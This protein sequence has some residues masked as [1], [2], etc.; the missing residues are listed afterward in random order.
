MKMKNSTF[1]KNFVVNTSLLLRVRILWWMHSRTGQWS[2]PD[3]PDGLALMGALP[4]QH[5]LWQ[6]PGVLHRRESVQTG[7]I[8]SSV[9]LSYPVLLRWQICWSLGD[10]GMWGTTLSSSTIAGLI[11]RGRHE[12]CPSRPTRRNIC[13][14]H[15]Q[16][17][18]I[19]QIS[20]GQTSTRPQKVSEWNPRSSRLYSQT[21]IEVWHLWGKSRFWSFFLLVCC[22]GSIY[23][24]RITVIWHAAAIRGYWDTWRMMPTLSQNG[25]DFYN[26]VS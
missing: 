16:L 10:T 22:Q 3:S 18:L 26:T 12:Y 1:F 8:L 21:R 19:I 4:V 24:N 15:C 9:H 14:V 17:I 6:R 7:V 23:S 2:Q 20:G 11:I 13:F 5:R 25:V